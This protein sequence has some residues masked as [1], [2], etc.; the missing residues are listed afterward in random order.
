MGPLKSALAVLSHVRLLIPMPLHSDSDIVQGQAVSSLLGPRVELPDAP[1]LPPRQKAQAFRTLWVV[2]VIRLELPLSHSG[3]MDGLA[4][5]VLLGDSVTA[6]SFMVP[7]TPGLPGLFSCMQAQGACTRMGLLSTVPAMPL[8][9]DQLV[10]KK[11][12]FVLV[13]EEAQGVAI[14]SCHHTI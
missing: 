3:M 1:P 7:T 5:T 8:L 12:A 2:G 9:V 4:L 6:G 10:P 13:Q 14:M 11:V